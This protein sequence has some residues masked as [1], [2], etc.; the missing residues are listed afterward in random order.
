M[1]F[2]ESEGFKAG[3]KIINQVRI[4]GWIKQNPIF[5]AAC[6][7]YSTLSVL[8]EIVTL[9]FLFLE[10]SSSGVGRKSGTTL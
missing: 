1:D 3:N 6:L 2:F 8:R 7:K 10:A 4:P 5:L 9:V